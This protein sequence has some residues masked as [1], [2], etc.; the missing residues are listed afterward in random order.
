MIV[1][2]CQTIYD[3]AV[4]CFK[5]QW[6]LSENVK[7]R[8]ITQAVYDQAACRM[9]QVGYTRALKEVIGMG[10]SK[11]VY[12]FL[13]GAH[14]IPKQEKFGS[15]RRDYTMVYA[16]VR[17][18][19]MGF[20]YDTLGWP[21][22]ELVARLASWTATGSEVRTDHPVLGLLENGHFAEVAL[23]LNDCVA[24]RHGVS[25]DIAYACCAH[26]DLD[27]LV[28]FKQFICLDMIHF[29]LKEGTS[30][31]GLCWLWTFHPALFTGKKGLTRKPQRI[32]AMV[33]RKASPAVLACLVDFGYLDIARDGRM[34]YEYA[35]KH[36]HTRGLAWIRQMY[37]ELPAWF[38]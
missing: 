29:T 20:I 6:T 36:G 11:K 13:T 18:A 12:L 33:M 25:A 32:I 4:D 37:K 24:Q 38:V 27:S 1:S 14:V 23:F 30:A 34:I 26:G 31:A 17:H 19:Q 5:Y 21:R 8:G 2:L 7:R 15:G 10:G 28:R 22:S 16:A 35:T 3:D 9:I